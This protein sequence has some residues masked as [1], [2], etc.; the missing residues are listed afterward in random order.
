M[1]KVLLLCIGC[2]LAASTAFADCVV[3][4]A[5]LQTDKVFAPTSFWYKPVP[6]GEVLN[7]NNANLVT[8]FNRQ[9]VKYY[10]TVEINTTS[11]ASPVYTVPADTPTTKVGWNN[12]QNKS[13]VETAMLAQLAAVPIPANAV[14][15]SGT[16]TEITIY[17]PSTDTVWEMWQAK[18]DANGAWIA[19]WGGKLVNASTSEGI[20]PKP[21]GTTATGLPFIGG[22]I[23]AEELER[24]E[25]KHALGIALV[26]TEHY[27]KYSWPA[28]RSDG[29]NPSNLPNRIQEGA[30]FRFDPSI[31]FDTY[32][33]LTRAARI[34][35]KAGQKYGFVVWDKAGAVS[36]RAQ[37][38]SSY[39][40][41]NP[42]PALF[43]NK[44]TYEILKTLPWNSIQFL[45][46][47]YGKPN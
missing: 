6:V 26:E 36:L 5:A 34:I 47:N 13:W 8:E 41:G 44:P 7:V 30:R 39:P 45:P 18:K 22:Q 2:A 40:N 21:Y 3:S 12:C 15:A 1:K 25:I 24:G 20:M 10:N 17:Q 9:R 19:C 42:Y 4:L 23:T 27:N 11:Y 43:D 38:P 37:N 46:Y 35:A 31:D 33:G 32:P 28:N 14:P 16:D 29:W